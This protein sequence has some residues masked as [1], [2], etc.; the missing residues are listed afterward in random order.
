MKAAKWGSGRAPDLNG[1]PKR[2]TAILVDRRTGRVGSRH[3]E[4]EEGESVRRLTM[5]A[6]LSSAC[7]L[8]AIAPAARS[9][10]NT[11]RTRPSLP[12]SVVALGYHGGI[13]V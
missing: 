9:G 12:T 8:A 4:R 1:R 3:G 10:A 11:R 5:V 2:S 6:L 7:V 13:A